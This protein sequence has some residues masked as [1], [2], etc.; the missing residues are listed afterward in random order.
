MSV[1]SAGSKP[2]GQGFKLADVCIFSRAP[3]ARRYELFPY[4]FSIETL[5]GGIWLHS[6][7]N[8]TIG[9]AASLLASHDII[10]VS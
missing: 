10:S 9:P 6:S 2:E 7:M 5:Q 4:F 8:S 3:L 1:G